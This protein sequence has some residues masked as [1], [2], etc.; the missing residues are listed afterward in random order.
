MDRG[1]IDRMPFSNP[2]SPS[3]AAGRRSAAYVLFTGALLSSCADRPRAAESALALTPPVIDTLTDGTIAV[4]NTGPAEWDGTNGWHF[5]LALEIAPAEDAPSAFGNPSGPA[6]PAM[7]MGVNPEFSILA[8][9]ALD[10]FHNVYVMERSPWRLQVF[11]SLGNPVRTIGREGEG[12]GEYRSGIVAIEGDTLIL[13]RPQEAMVSFYSLD[14]EFLSSHRGVCCYSARQIITDTAGLIWIPGSMLV[15]GKPGW[16]LTRFDGQRERVV[17]MPT[18]STIPWPPKTWTWPVTIQGQAATGFRRI[19]LQPLV[20]HAPRRDGTVISGRTD[21]AEFFVWTSAGDTIRRF[22]FP[23]TP[24][25]LSD[26][27]R[28]SIVRGEMGSQAERYP[29]TVSRLAPDLPRQ[30]PAWQRFSVDPE[31]NVWVGIGGGRGELTRLLVF[32]PEG[33]LRGEVTPPTSAFFQGVWGDGRIVV[34]EENEDGE[35]LVR[36]YRLI[37]TR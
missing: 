33:I 15:D 12:P 19:P 25:P 35:P 3:P 10:R 26:A 37:R 14:G 31:G 9:V 22:S 4:T 16:A 21:R 20:D 34:P 13:Q 32:S 27:E 17:V 7:T 24:V 6:A 23:F 1:H 29:S 28:D 11:D 5:E 36:V 2:S 8:S 18:D 30:W